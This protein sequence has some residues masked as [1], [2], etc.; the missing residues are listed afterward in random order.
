MMNLA[1]KSKGRRKRESHSCVARWLTIHIISNHLNS[2]IHLTWITITVVLN[3]T[4]C[5]NQKRQTAEI[6]QTQVFQK[7]ITLLGLAYHHNPARLEH[8]LK[9]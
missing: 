6:K 9:Q 5:R 1:R 2:M 8:S 7:S 4:P 3:N